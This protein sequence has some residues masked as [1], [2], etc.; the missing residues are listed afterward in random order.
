VKDGW[1]GELTGCG[2]VQYEYTVEPADFLLKVTESN[3]PGGSIVTVH[4]SRI[5]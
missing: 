1:D 2:S 4:S 3:W 5:E